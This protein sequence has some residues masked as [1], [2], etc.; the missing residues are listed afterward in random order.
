MRL[1]PT[2]PRQPFAPILRAAAAAFRAHAHVDAERWAR[3]LEDLSE[4]RALPTVVTPEILDL[5]TGLSELA[6]VPI[7][8]ADA[9]LPASVES[10]SD[11]GALLALRNAMLDASV[12]LLAE[13]S[14][15]MPAD[16]RLN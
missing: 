12:L 11:L 10:A 2:P 14:A 5:L 15:E 9:L 7:I 13:L 6:K 8:T 4:R 3:L 16:A 1:G